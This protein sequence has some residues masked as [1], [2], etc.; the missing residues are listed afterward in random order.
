VTDSG[1]VYLQLGAVIFL[2]GVGGRV[3]GRAGMSPIPLYLIAGL[4]LS[5]FDIPALSGDFVEFAAGLGVILLLFLIG[6]EYTVEELTEGLRRSFR[7]GLLD[8]ALNF[9]PGFLLGLALG[10]DVTAAVLLGGV[11]YVTS[12]GIVVKALS[13]L[14]RT[15]CPE[16]PTVLSLLLGEDLAMAAFL[17]L[18]A[19]LVIGGGVLATLGSLLLAALAAIA[20]FIGA[21][22][23]GDPLGRIVHHRSEEIALLSALG[24]VLMVA[25][26][27]EKL[28]LPAAVGAFLIGIALSDEVAHRTRTLLAPIRDVNVALFFLFF[29][30]QIDT[31]ELPGVA[32]PALGLALVT[33]VTK[34]VTGWRAAVLAGVGEAG[35][36]RAA[37]AMIPRGEMSIVLATVGAKL[38][39]ELAP[40]GAAYV[41]ILAIAGTVLMRFSDLILRFAG[42]RPG[43]VTEA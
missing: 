40:L 35:R 30:L 3:A 15:R 8:V 33:A 41:L 27:A 2:L 13:D 9:P 14:G 12:S 43:L 19:A 4:A 34:G 38:E 16:T 22:C 25:G 29:A 42:A 23:F 39:P 18:A 7:A 5:A 1:S 28:Q 10:W 17:P 24:L 20:A 37:V 6:L 31:G 21:L 32:L 11:T 36:A 26:L